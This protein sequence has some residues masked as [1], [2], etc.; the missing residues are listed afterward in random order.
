M[1]DGDGDGG[2]ID[3]IACFTQVRRGLG[4]FGETRTNMSSMVGDAGR[5]LSAIL[6]VGESRSG[7]NN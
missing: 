4:V 7:I 6:S 2:C 1:N 5:F 3:A